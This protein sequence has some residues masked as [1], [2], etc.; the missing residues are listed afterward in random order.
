[1]KMKLFKTEK[2]KQKIYVKVTPENLIM[3]PLNRVH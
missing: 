2:I 3:A 1:M